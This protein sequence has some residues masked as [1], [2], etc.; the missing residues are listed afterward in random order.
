[1]PVYSD[2]DRPARNR[3]A[4]VDEEPSVRPDKYFRRRT[5]QRATPDRENGCAPGWGSAPALTRH[6]ETRLRQRAITVDQVLMIIDFGKEQRSHG[7]SRFF[8]DKVARNR[9]I[10]AQPSA[11]RDLGSLDIQVV[12]ADD[13]RLITAAHRTKRI[14]RDIQRT[15][16]RRDLQ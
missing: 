12:L 8:L 1:M 10:Q 7:A 9:L 3:P 11:M 5:A 2:T 13:G 15:Y 16:R 4:E 14:R 6:A